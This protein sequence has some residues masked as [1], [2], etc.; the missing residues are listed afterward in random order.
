MTKSEKD[1][2]I[3]GSSP[4]ILP[5]EIEEALSNYA[6]IIISGYGGLNVDWESLYLIFRVVIHSYAPETVWLRGAAIPKYTRDINSRVLMIKVRNSLAHIQK[7]IESG[8]TTFAGLFPC[9]L[10]NHPKRAGTHCMQ[11]LRRFRVASHVELYDKGSRYKVCFNLNLLTSNF[12]TTLPFIPPAPVPPPPKGVN[13]LKELRDSIVFK[14]RFMGADINEEVY[15]AIKATGSDEDKDNLELA[16]ALNGWPPFHD[17][18]VDEKD[19]GWDKPF[20]ALVS[21]IDSLLEPFG[22]A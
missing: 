3:N 10:S 6:K 1:N 17:H 12:P 21:K 7:D 2:I 14:Y 22:G 15:N 19:I 4:V 8:D 9:C 16:I 13:L 11:I 18:S 20:K 5:E